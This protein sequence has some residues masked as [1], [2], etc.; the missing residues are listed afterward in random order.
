MIFKYKVQG[1]R[2]HHIITCGRARE[3]SSSCL[4]VIRF[5]N[6]NTTEC[7][8]TITANMKLQNCV[9]LGVKHQVVGVS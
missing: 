5:G 6:Y 9:V 3:V 1:D 2:N 4:C 8:V 7:L